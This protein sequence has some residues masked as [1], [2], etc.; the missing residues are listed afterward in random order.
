M[1]GGR[2]LGTA[3]LAGLTLLGAGGATAVMLHP[4]AA[5]AGLRTAT[6]VTSAPTGREDL[7]DERTVKVSLTQLPTPPLVVGIGGRV[8]RISCKAGRPLRSGQ[9]VARIDDT[10]VIALATR[11]PLYRDLGYGDKG[12]DVRALQRELRRLGHD[13]VEATGRYDRRTRAA[14]R[15]IQK[16]AK[17]DDPEGTITVGE[18]LWLPAPSVVPNACELTLGAYVSAGQTFAKVPPRLT[19][20]VVNSLPSGIVPGERGI[21]VLGESGPL[22]SQGAATDPG[23]LSRVAAGQEY[24][25][26]LASGEKPDLSGIIRL[27]KAVPTVKVPPGSVFALDGDRGCVQSGDTGHPV[28]VVGSRLGATLVTMKGAVPPEVAVGPAITLESCR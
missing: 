8:T 28:T 13:E 4:A 16:K 12:D 23:F 24:R 21:E 9:T 26:L 15:A 19:A 27:R 22:N 14:V 18:I 2:T 17:V 1:A 10:P 6:E 5:P 7:T 11:T 20:V 3:L 25:L